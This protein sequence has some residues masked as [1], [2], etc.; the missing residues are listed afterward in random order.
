MSMTSIRQINGG[1]ELQGDV[2]ALLNIVGKDKEAF[3]N[4]ILSW[5]LSEAPQDF[6]PEILRS[7]KL[8]KLVGSAIEVNNKPGA[9]L[10][11]IEENDE[12]FTLKMSG[13]TKTWDGVL[14]YSTDNQ[15]WNEWSGTEISSSTY[16]ELYLRGIN[17][18]KLSTPSVVGSFV[19]TSNKHIQ[20][21]GNIENLLD[22]KTVKEGNHPKMGN[23]CYNSLF[24]NCTS[25]TTAPELPA[26]EL[27]S[28]CYYRMFEGCKSLKNAPELPAVD[29]TNGCYQYMFRGCTS[30][31]TAP[32]LLAT[33]LTE[34]CYNAMFYGCT[35]LEIPPELPATLL[36]AGCYRDMFNGC[37]S[38]VSI[39]EL[40]AI[41][42]TPYCYSQMFK[43]CNSIKTPPERMPATVLATK[44]YYA[45]LPSSVSG[46]IHCPA[47][48]TPTS[49][50]LAPPNKST[51]I[52]YDL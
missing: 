4:E 45:M 15:N 24:L 16:G 30:I 46:I 32:K 10:G 47:S 18:T 26:T 29:L 36:G 11:F 17:N 50:R 34:V 14:E 31:K 13:Q 2:R 7:S 12:P 38:L 5:L 51:Q 49:E 48:S 40:P 52:I 33:S 41:T 42:L 23:T 6:N 1:E 27:S 21:N 28:S 19:L 37:T 25:L 44:C 20:C 43:D 3:F 39:P 35:S 8:V 22:Y 9:Y